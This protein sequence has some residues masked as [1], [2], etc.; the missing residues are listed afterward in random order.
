MEA[1]R[2]WG[3]GLCVSAVACFALQFL[4][5]AKG[6]GN[7]FRVLVITFF[8]CSMISPLLTWRSAMSPD[9]ALL[10]DD[11]VQDSLQQ[12]VNEQ[13]HEQVREK[14]TE[15]T[16]ECL[17]YRNVAAEKIEVETDIAENGSIYIKQVV[18]T[19]DKQKL[20]AA[21]TAEEVLETQLGTDVT[22]QT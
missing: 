8:L 3:V 9:M 6:T 14:V 13:L 18:I 4:F 17:K 1:I 11:V 5:P 19:V 20:S 7:V 16:E 10:P 15:I 22:I 21:I 12:K 2:Q